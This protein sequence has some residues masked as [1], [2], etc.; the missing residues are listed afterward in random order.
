[1]HRSRFSAATSR[2]VGRL[3]SGV[4]SLGRRLFLKRSLS[5]G[6]L[7][8]TSQGGVAAPV[9]ANL[10]PGRARRVL[11]VDTREAPNWEEANSIL[12]IAWTNLG[13]DYSDA[14]GRRQG[15]AAF[16][17]A[18]ISN[19]GVQVVSW[20]IGPLVQKL[21]EHNTGIYIKR[22]SGGGWANFASRESKTYAGPA[23]EVKTNAGSFD[24][25]LI[26][27]TYLARGSPSQGSSDFLATPILLKFDLSRVSG[28]VTSA[29]LTMTSFNQGSLRSLVLGAYLLEM[30]QLVTDPATELGGVEQGIAATVSRNDLDL[31]KHPSVLVYNEMSS[32]DEIWNDEWSVIVPAGP[33]RSGGHSPKRVYGDWTYD[34]A[35]IPWPEYGLTAGRVTIPIN[36]GRVTV[37][38]AILHHWVTPKNK[39]PWRWQRD[40]GN[41]YDEMYCRYLLYVDPDV[42]TG[43]IPS[44]GVKLPGLQGTYGVDNKGQYPAGRSAWSYRMEH[45]GPSPA[46]PGVFRLFIYA[47]DWTSPIGTGSGQ[48]ILSKAGVCLASGKKYCIEQHVKL[49]TQAADGTWN[50]DGVI[51]IWVDGVRIID[52]RDRLIRKDPNVQIQSIPFLNFYHGGMEPPNADI[53][54]QVTGVCAATQYI[55]PPKRVA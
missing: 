48:P 24:A 2:I 49:N 36:P 52:I 32:R 50:S 33:L 23:L 44:S 46:H 51:R 53:H 30:P 13:G 27:D 55:G 29:I 34:P 14:D 10:P 45:L 40:L 4:T 18:T 1:M 12:Q 20:S 43:M 6:A 31:R 7:A 15:S 41:G 28:T 5:L 35:Y 26:A 54:Y 19:H 21:T 9:G 47:Y 22:D 38:G 3:G 8:L 37:A 17:Q 16:A 11:L 25:P 39:R 42:A